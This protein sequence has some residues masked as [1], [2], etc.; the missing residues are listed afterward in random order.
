MD[1]GRVNHLWQS[2][3]LLLAPI[4]LTLDAQGRVPDA[5]G[6]LTTGGWGGTR[7]GAPCAAYRCESSI[8]KESKG[9]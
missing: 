1:W 6:R 3:N 9:E 8:V 7:V 2:V 4:L 5:G